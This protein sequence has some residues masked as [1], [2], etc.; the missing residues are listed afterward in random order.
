[1]ELSIELVSLGQVR[2]VA[3]GTSA[4]TPAAQ[5]QAWIIPDGSGCD[6]PMLLAPVLL[7]TDV[8]S[9]ETFVSA[10]QRVPCFRLLLV[11]TWN[12]F[13]FNELLEM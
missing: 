9:Q 2:V 3:M 6:A 8:C 10:S 1:M 13:L 4:Q 7:G 12:S 5:G 11:T